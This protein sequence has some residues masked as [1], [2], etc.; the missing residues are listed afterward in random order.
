MSQI[1]ITLVVQ[2]GKL[3]ENLVHAYPNGCALTWHDFP[4]DILRMAFK[5]DVP[6]PY[7][8]GNA[9]WTTLRKPHSCLSQRIWNSK[10]AMK[11]VGLGLRFRIEY[12]LS[13]SLKIG[14]IGLGL[15]QT[16]IKFPWTWG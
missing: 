16:P 11:G 7:N 1:F 12:F 9:G 2:S 5:I 3:Q 8:L 6:N 15:G 10:K 4:K 14:K 13:S